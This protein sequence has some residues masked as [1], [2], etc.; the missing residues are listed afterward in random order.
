MTSKTSSQA[1]LEVKDYSVS[2]ETFQLLYNDEL[3]M[4]ETFPQPSSQ[5]LPDY[6]KS[7]D[8]ISHT[9]AKRNLFER[10]Y[11]LVKSISLKRKL[12]LINYVVKCEKHLL[13]VGCGTGDFL[14]IAIK[15][16]WTV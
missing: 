1:Y 7:E 3:G 14:Q 5:K 6:Y 15:N 2:G 16:S 10:A 9:D 8:Y 11:H 13:D 12:N 4:L